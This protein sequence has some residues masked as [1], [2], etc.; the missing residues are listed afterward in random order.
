MPKT[1]EKI[2]LKYIFH[3]LLFEILKRFASSQT[4]I[5]DGENVTVQVTGISF[6]LVLLIEPLVL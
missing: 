2:D 6:S 4:F 5:R 1:Y 3:G